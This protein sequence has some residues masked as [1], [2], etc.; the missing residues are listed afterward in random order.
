M[1]ARKTIQVQGHLRSMISAPIVVRKLKARIWD[2][3]LVFNSNLGAIL[4][5]FRDIRACVRW[6]SVF[7][8]P[9]L[10][11]PKFLVYWVC[12]SWIR[13]VMHVGVTLRTANGPPR[14][15]IPGNFRRRPTETYAIRILQRHTQRTDTGRRTDDL[16]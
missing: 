14:Q 10:F 7:P 5:R 12:S 3:L 16:P 15:T 8:Y 4:S 11:W 13:S 9:T 1:A 6:K 2:F